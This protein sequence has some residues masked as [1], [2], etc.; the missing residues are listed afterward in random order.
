MSLSTMT[1]APPIAPPPAVP[2]DFKRAWLLAPGGIWMLLFLLLP[3][4]MMVYVRFWAQTTFTIGPEL[5]LDSWRAFCATPPYVGA[6]WT[7]IGLWSSVLLGCLLLGY[8]VALYIGFFVRKKGGQTMLL[9]LFVIS[10][11]T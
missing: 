7:T 1:L 9:V 4:S 6:L 5:T 10:F 2:A 8:P 3:M 11:F